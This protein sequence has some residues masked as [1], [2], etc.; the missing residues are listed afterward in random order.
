MLPVRIKDAPD[1]RPDNSSFFISGIR[2]D[3]KL[4]RRISGKAICTKINLDTRSCF[5]LCLLKTI[6]V[7]VKILPKVPGIG[8]FQDKYPA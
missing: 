8:S 1:I 7:I 6:P 2:L 3:T 5:V 4:P